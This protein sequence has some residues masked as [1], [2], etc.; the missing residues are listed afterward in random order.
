MKKPIITL[1]LLLLSFTFS[2]SQTAIQPQGTGTSSD[3]YQIASLS[4][5]Y[6]MSQNTSSWTKC[7]IQTADID[8]TATNGWHNGEGFSPIG[9]L[10]DVFSGVYNGQGYSISNLSINR[11]NDYSGLFGVT[12]YCKISNVIFVNPNITGGD[13]TGVL[14]GSS[15]HTD[16]DN[17]RLENVNVNGGIYCGSLVGRARYGD[18]YNCSASGIVDGQKYVGGLLGATFFLC[19][20]YDCFAD[21]EVVASDIIAGGFVGYC[22]YSYIN[23]CYALGNTEALSYIGGFVGYYMKYIEL[24]TTA[25]TNCFSHGDVI[26]NG[27]TLRVGGFAGYVLGGIEINNCYS[28]GSTLGNA[29]N[30][31]NHGFIGRTVTHSSFNENFFDSETSNQTTGIGATAKLTPEMKMQ[32]TF[33][34]WDFSNTWDMSYSISGFEGYPVA[35]WTNC[36][37]E[38][39]GVDVNGDFEVATASNLFWIASNTSNFNEDY[40][41]TADIDISHTVDFDGG[42]GFAPIGN[43]TSAF[44]GSYNGGGYEIDGLYIH[45]SASYIGFFGNTSG[46]QIRNVNLTNVNLQGNDYTGALIGHAYSATVIENCSSTGA[47]GGSAYLG[48]LIGYNELN[49]TVSNCYSSCS[50]VG[51]DSYCGGLIGYNNNSCC[52]VLSSYA[53]GDVSGLNYVG[54][55]IGKNEQSGNVYDSYA[56]GDVNG[57]MYVGGFIGEISSGGDMRGNYSSGSVTGISKVGG[58]AGISYSTVSD[59]YSISAVSRISGTNTEFGGFI[60]ALASGSVNCCYSV[61]TVDVG[62]LSSCGFIGSQ[63]GSTLSCFF[64][65]ETS[66]H[67]SSV[68][69]VPKTTTQMKTEST[70][71]GWS[72]SQAKSTGDWEMQ[73]GSTYVSYPYLKEINYDNPGTIGD[74]PIPGLADPATLPVEFLTFTNEFVAKNT[75]QLQWSTGSEQNSSHFIVQRSTDGENFENIGEVPAA[76]NSNVILDYHFVDMEAMGNIIYYRLKQVDYNGQ[77][78]HSKT[79]VVSK[80]DNEQMEVTAYPNPVQNRLS[81]RFSDEQEKV[82]LE[83]TDMNGRKLY[84]K[85]YSSVSDIQVDTGSWISGI[86]FLK[87]CSES[88]VA[89]HKLLKN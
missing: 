84:E 79:I 23:K 86:F 71:S 28:I 16:I 44:T 31:L 89:H 88:K 65:S 78:D 63:N 40:V 13:S 27:Y 81:I 1:S 53:S 64:D 60:G 39:P 33:S 58:F 32:S 72:F 5:L 2:F 36:G 10:S 24:K 6:W 3:P 22:N 61:G 17:V 56:S 87:I 9:S 37:V 19:N 34:T 77:Y 25:I 54:G 12:N 83:I 67:C 47:V 73:D 80:E 76:G 35:E 43:N 51:T 75:A 8:A 68:G 52:H 74:N 30:D 14:I 26:C 62:S 57:S 55:L 38:E 45:R 41:Q 82:L 21:V 85:E 20:V 49:S 59:S 48:G 69:A 15:D 11:Q 4:N 42:N 46:A 50:V 7:F 29:A 18:I 70:Y 66:G